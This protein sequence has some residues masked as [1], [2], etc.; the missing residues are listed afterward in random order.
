MKLGEQALSKTVNGSSNLSEGTLEIAVL[1]RSRPG[2]KFRRV[3]P[4][5]VREL[6]AG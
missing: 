6:L 4:D 2:R 3:D 5:E 1:E